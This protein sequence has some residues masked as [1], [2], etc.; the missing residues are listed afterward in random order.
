MS[1]KKRKTN[2]FKPVTSSGSEVAPA[3]STGKQE[4]SSIPHRN[5]ER[6]NVTGHQGNKK[7][8]EQAGD[9]LCKQEVRRLP[10]QETESKVA[11]TTGAD[12]EQCPQKQNNSKILSGQKG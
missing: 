12:A 11:S 10:P 4:V 3:S 6:S 5:P 2:R 8:A 1:T 7:K 9:I